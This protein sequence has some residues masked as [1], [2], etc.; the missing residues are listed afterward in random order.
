MRTK[1]VEWKESW[2][3]GNEDLDNDHKRLVGIIN[4]VSNAEDSGEDV[5]WVLNDLKEYAN[6]HFRC[7][8]ELMEAAQIPG[9]EEHKQ[10]HRMFVEWLTSLQRTVNLPEARYILFEAAN[11]YLRDWLGKH[12]LSTDMQYKGKL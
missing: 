12:I 7:E 9:L 11:E 5:V 4:R 1:P 2:S 3:V 8:E 10:A 6:L